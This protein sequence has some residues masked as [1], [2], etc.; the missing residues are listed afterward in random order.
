MK[1]F[2]I[3]AL[4]DDTRWR[5]IIMRQRGLN[6][7]ARERGG[8]FLIQIGAAELVRQI[9]IVLELP[10]VCFLQRMKAERKLENGIEGG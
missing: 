6:E 4:S 5:E 7:L 10:P 1:P 3:P 8:G 2:L 9:P